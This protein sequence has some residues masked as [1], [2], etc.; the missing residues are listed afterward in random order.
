M[1]IDFRWAA[2]VVAIWVVFAALVAA[3]TAQEAKPAEGGAAKITYD[4]NVR[5]IFRDHCFAC[6]AQDHNKGGLTLDTYAKA[7]AGGSSGEVV[8]AGD[9][10]SSRLWALVSHMEQPNMPPMTE[11]LPQPK[12][13]LISKWIEGGAPE[14][15]GSKVVLKKNNLTVAATTPTGQPEGP[16]A[17]P[18]GVLRQPVMFTPRAAA[19]SAIASSPWAPL[20]A[21]A[22]QK[23]VALYNTDSAQLLGILPFPEGIPYVLRF[24]RSGS[25]LLAGGGRGGHSGSVVLYDVKTGRRIAKIGEEVDSVLAADISKDHSMVALGGPSKIVRIYS[26]ETGQLLHEIKKHTD[27]IYSVQFSPDGVL[28]ATT[29]RSGGVF[30]WEA[31]TARE[32]LNLRGHNGAVCDVS[33]RLDSNILASAG[34]DTTVKLWEMNDGNA[35]KSWGAH[36][37]GVFC[38]RYTHDGRIVTAGRDNTVKSWNGDG[39]ALKTFPGFPEAGLRCAFTYDGKRVVGGDWLGNIRIWEAE[40]A[41]E[42]FAVAANPPTLA[43]VIET[44]KAALPPVQTAATAAATELAAAVQVVAAADAALKA[45]TDKHN[46]A[47]AAAPKAEA[48]RVAA[49]KANEV[50]VAAVKTATDALTAAQAAA[51]TAT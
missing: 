42:A 49:V 45:S 40:Q 16:P 3:A 9:L 41:A 2:I 51:K 36:G 28:L 27:W 12:L 22:G 47:V 25:I 11:K 33:W 37:G 6:H 23:Q 46:A 39:A 44:R 10:S 29:D 34:E 17:M 8:V 20:A 5:A 21:V 35:I 30:V 13:D 24:S 43:M 18:E 31:D 1:R 50:A 48:D 7:M 15:S 32:Y 19:I 14:N 26:S 38:V 4:D